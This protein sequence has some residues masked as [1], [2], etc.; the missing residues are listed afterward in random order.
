MPRQLLVLKITKGHEVRRVATCHAPF[1]N[2]AFLKFAK[3]TTK[4]GAAGG[5][6]RDKVLVRTGSDLVAN[7]RAGRVLGRN[8]QIQGADWRI[9]DWDSEVSSDHS[10]VFIDTGGAAVAVAAPPAA[11]AAAAAEPEQKRPSLSRQ[12]GEI[13]KGKK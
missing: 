4:S 2:G 11:A 8:A 13:T 1:G 6:P 5:S 10:P 12:F 7:A 3:A 9:A